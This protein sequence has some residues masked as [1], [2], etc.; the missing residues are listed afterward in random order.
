LVRFGNR[1][2]IVAVMVAGRLRLWNGW[3]VD[4][5]GRALMRQITAGAS[6]VMRRAPIKRIHPTSDQHRLMTGKRDRTGG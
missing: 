6:D 2:Q 5:D 1:D 4:W 3:P